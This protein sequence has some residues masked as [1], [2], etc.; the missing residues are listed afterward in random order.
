[1]FH[2]LFLETVCAQKVPGD[3]MDINIIT[4]CA[5]SLQHV[6]N[7]VRTLSL[8][9]LAEKETNTFAWLMEVASV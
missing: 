4:Y 5:T 1:M 3:V 9:V 8:G 6:R 2:R 7:L